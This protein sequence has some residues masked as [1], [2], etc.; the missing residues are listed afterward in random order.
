VRDVSV[1]LSPSGHRP[2]GAQHRL[3]ASNSGSGDDAQ[4]D[5]SADPEA[6]NALVIPTIRADRQ[7]PNAEAVG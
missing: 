7:E 5:C 3:P 4:E 2:H 6:P 1:A